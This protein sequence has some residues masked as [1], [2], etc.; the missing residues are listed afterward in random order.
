MSWVQLPWMN[1]KQHSFEV[2]TL[3]STAGP[4]MNTTQLIGCVMNV[5]KMETWM[6][7]FVK[8]WIDIYLVSKVPWAFEVCSRLPKLLQPFTNVVGLAH[9]HHH[10][11]SPA[12][13]WRTSISIGISISSRSSAS[14]CCSSRSGEPGGGGHS[15]LIHSWPIAMR[16]RQILRSAPLDAFLVGGMLPPIQRPHQ[17]LPQSSSYLIPIC[18][19]L[20]YALYLPQAPHIQISQ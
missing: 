11:I 7:E 15:Q 4:P 1:L 12:Q 8:S 14:Y 5:L 6:N 2:F 10:H 18:N 17:D 19:R 16:G 20:S 9:I 13:S 3:E